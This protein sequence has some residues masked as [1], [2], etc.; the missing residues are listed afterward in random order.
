MSDQ[1]Y[2]SQMVR[3]I[4]VFVQL[5][6][7]ITHG[8]LI[9]VTSPSAHSPSTVSIVVDQYMEFLQDLINPPILAHDDPRQ[10][11][12]FLQRSRWA[13]WLQGL[14]PQDIKNLQGLLNP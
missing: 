14:G 8:G 5:L 11:H 6:F 4:L 2:S 10:I 9:K 3:P 12:P 7:P 1:D 13:S